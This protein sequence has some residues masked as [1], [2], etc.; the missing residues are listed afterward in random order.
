MDDFLKGGR[1]SRIPHCLYLPELAVIAATLVN[2]P[3]AIGGTGVV[4]QV[5]LGGQAE[6]IIQRQGSNCPVYRGAQ[7]IRQASAA[8]S[9][10]VASPAPSLRLQV[11]LSPMPDRE[12]DN[13]VYHRQANPY[14]SQET[15]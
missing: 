10:D 2:T 11:L 15:Y 14:D 1:I 5:Y 13:Y 9:L 3:V 4:A 12:E 7:A 6:V 8:I